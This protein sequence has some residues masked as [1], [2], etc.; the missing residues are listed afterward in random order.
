MKIHV[1]KSYDPIEIKRW[2]IIENKKQNTY[3]YIKV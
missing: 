2:I 3:L 1:F